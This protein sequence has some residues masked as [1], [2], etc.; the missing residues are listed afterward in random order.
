MADAP[1]PRV[2]AISADDSGIADDITRDADDVERHR[3]PRC[4]VEPGPPCRSRSG[5]IVGTYHTGRFTAAP[6]PAK[7][8]R[9]QTPAN[10]SPGRPWRPGTPPPAPVNP[11]QPAA[12]IRI[13]YARCSSLTQELQSQ[14]DTLTAHGIGRD[15]IFSEKISTRVRAR[16]RVRGPG[17]RPADQGPRPAKPSAR[18]PWKA[19]TPQP[20]RATMAAARPSSPTT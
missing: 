15:E 10:R 17:R 3:C 14:L 11:D 12:D 5:A 1:Q 16:A 9:V 4:D 8:L 19:W 20:A 18:R 13:G 6:R 7:R 2:S